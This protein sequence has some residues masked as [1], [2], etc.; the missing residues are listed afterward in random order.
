VE[1]ITYYTES[2]CDSNYHSENLFC[3]AFTFVSTKDGVYIMLYVISPTLP[4]SI[5]KKE[6]EGY[7]AATATY[8]AASRVL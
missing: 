3:L 8:A 6:G 2:D 4:F 5:W 7:G 1:L